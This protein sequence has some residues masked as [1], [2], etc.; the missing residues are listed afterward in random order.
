MA[1]I[2]SRC[3][4]DRLVFTILRVVDLV[5]H[6][7]HSSVPHEPRSAA[8]FSVTLAKGPARRETICDKPETCVHADAGAS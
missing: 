1:S 4:P 2:Q 3:Q 7:A 5:L 6:F 8:I